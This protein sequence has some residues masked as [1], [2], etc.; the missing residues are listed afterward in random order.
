[1]SSYNEWIYN[2]ST[3]EINL[4]IKALEYEQLYFK[5]MIIGPEGIGV[6]SKISDTIMELC[7]PVESGIILVQFHISDKLEFEGLY[8]HKDKSISIRNV[9]DDTTLLHE[10]IH[11]YI[12][13]LEEINPAICECLLVDL[14]KTLSKRINNIDE[15]ILEHA[16]L[17]SLT[18]LETY[19]G[20]HGVLFLLKSYD[21]DL[22]CKYNL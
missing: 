7:D 21:L 1:M 5:D 18:R 19:G 14:Y 12:D 6:I 20:I 9:N 3:E 4:Q 13:N 15:L 16:E 11:F 17:S 10:M 2:R 8:N 22:K